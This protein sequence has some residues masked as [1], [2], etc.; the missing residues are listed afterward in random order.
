MSATPG[1]LQPQAL[2]RN[3]YRVLRVIKSGGMGAVYEV[4][5]EVTAARRALK[6]MLP[7]LVDSEELRARFALEA[8]VTG[9][10][11]SDHIVRTSDAGVDEESGTPFLVMELLRGEELGS[12]VKKRGA[13]PP[14]EVALYLFQAA[15]ALDR[16]H[17]ANIIHRDL[18]PDNLF[19]TIRDDG[20]PCVKIL[21]F[22]IAKV[23]EQ[24]QHDTTLTRQMLGTPVY[25]AP[26]QIRA[27]RDVGPPV[28]IH[29]LG[30]VAYTLLAGESYWAPESEVIPSPYMLAAELVRGPIEAPSIR[31]QR[32]RS[33]TLPAD[34]DAWFFKTTA[35]KPEDRF[36]RASTAISALAD[37]LGVTL[38]RVSR[39]V[40][41]PEPPPDAA[42]PPVGPSPTDA[43]LPSR[44][45]T[46]QPFASVPTIVAQEVQKTPLSGHPSTGAPQHDNP[47]SPLSSR[48]ITD[49]PQHN[50]T[51]DTW[52]RPPL[53]VE[54]AARSSPPSLVAS[55]R[56]PDAMT[57]SRRERVP[58]RRFQV[59]TDPSTGILRVKV[60]GFWDIEEGKAYLEEFRQKASTLLGKPWYVLADI[61]DFQAQKPDVSPYVEQT[62]TF[63]R[64]NGMRRAA[65]LVNSALS[66]MQ[67]S[68]L[69]ADT[70]LPEYSFFTVESQAVAWLLKG[71]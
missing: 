13:L 26:E 49:A 32:R 69:S 66:K 17:A 65:N 12:L 14:E 37:A 46:S 27:A 67:I 16:T 54:G 18:K 20:S 6:V 48:S 10:I 29:A 44:A 40:L 57:S 7:S 60:W 38:P 2:F 22:G 61:A 21:D 30:H 3:R 59:T 71:D 15:L 33:R 11:E 53:S 51:P 28:D 58:Q 63:A 4:L 31:A 34:I 70:G 56:S 55:R 36:D 24:H 42:A 35:V 25:M 5:D 39:V 43:T 64:E 1:A 52:A 23:L 8:R 50:K 19:V 68:R 47:K 45:P 9:A 41:V 62:M